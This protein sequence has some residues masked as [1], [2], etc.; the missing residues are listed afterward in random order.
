MNVPMATI[1][2]ENQLA[3]NAILS[4]GESLVI[5]LCKSP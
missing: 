4:P 2:T 5:P 3:N 1:E